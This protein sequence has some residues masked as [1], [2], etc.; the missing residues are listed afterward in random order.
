[1]IKA[2]NFLRRMRLSGQRQMRPGN[3]PYV[4]INMA[5]WDITIDPPTK[6]KDRQRSDLHSNL[7]SLFLPFAQFSFLFPRNIVIVPHSIFIVRSPSELV[8][9]KPYS[10]VALNA[11]VSSRLAFFRSLTL[12]FSFLSPRPLPHCTLTIPPVFSHPR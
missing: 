10:T 6:G 3:E 8:R 12:D 2:P 4:T 11:Y 7:R 9:S 1:M 5:Q